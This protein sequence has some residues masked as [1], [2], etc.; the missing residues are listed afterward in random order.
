[1]TRFKV[2]I[3][4]FKYLSSFDGKFSKLLLHGTISGP[5][6]I[7]RIGSSNMY[8]AILSDYLWEILGRK[9]GHVIT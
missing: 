8:R 3:S 9:L 2:S 5:G 7:F 4:I 6:L 1:M